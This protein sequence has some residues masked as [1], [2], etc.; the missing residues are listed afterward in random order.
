MG[1]FMSKVIILISG[2]PATGKT[3][4]ASWL[5]T[6]LKIPLVCY[7]NIKS[8]LSSAYD[9]FWFMLEEICKSSSPVIAD[10]IFTN[11]TN[12]F[13]DNMSNKYGYKIISVHFDCDT[14][15]AYERF[16]ERAKNIEGGDKIRLNKISFDEF[17]E[18]VKQNKNFNYG[19]VRIDVNTN[20]FETISYQQILERINACFAK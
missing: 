19:N 3:S 13:I 16:L 12:E 10:Y 14:E 6:E 9:M 15:I 18:E 1:K 5:S 17:N 4:F 7:D 8:K 11:Q 20:N 2:M